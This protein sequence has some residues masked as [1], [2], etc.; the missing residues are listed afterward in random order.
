MAQN[1]VSIGMDSQKKKKNQLHHHV[2]C[3]TLV[4][5]FTIAIIKML[6]IVTITFLLPKVG[7][8]SMAY[9]FKFAWKVAFT[10]IV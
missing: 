5:L 7:V 3:F 1:A 9:W 4:L 8:V 10:V 6:C 2:H